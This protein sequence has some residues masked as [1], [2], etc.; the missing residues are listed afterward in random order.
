[1]RVIIDIE[2]RSRCDLVRC[3]GYRY[4]E[5]PS[6]EVRQFGY[7]IGEQPVHV[8]QPWRDPMPADLLAALTS[9]CVLV[10]HNAGFE[11]AVLTGRAGAAIGMPPCIADLNRWSCT[12]ARAA[13]LGL[14]RG[15]DQVCR[16][17]EARAA[18]GRRGSRADAACLH[19]VQ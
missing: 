9:D 19:S 16:A 11:R 18:E 6:T 3:G 5:D 4:A 17:L 1:M 7:Q 15:L 2:T 13:A 14:A 10:A 8:W 12:A